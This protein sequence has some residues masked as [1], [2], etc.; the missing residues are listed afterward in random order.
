MKQNRTAVQELC[1]RD[2]KGVETQLNFTRNRNSWESHNV[3]ITS[4]YSGKYRCERR[5]KL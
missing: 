1:E 4:L 5:E 3:T 2:K